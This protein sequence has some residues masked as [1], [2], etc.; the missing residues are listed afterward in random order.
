[1]LNSPMT[2]LKYKVDRIL[3]KTP[4]IPVYDQLK[5]FMYDGH[6]S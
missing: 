2:I 3:D 5:L 1:M 6:D 4:S